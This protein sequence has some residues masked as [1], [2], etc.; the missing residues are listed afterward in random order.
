MKLDGVA[1]FVTIAEAGSISAAARRMG[2]P[3][4]VVS[5]RL[6]ELERFFGVRLMQ[7]TTRRLSL[8][9]DGHA[10]LERATRMVRDAREGAAEM[11]ERRGQLAGPLRISGPSSF[12]V[13]HLGPALYP[14]LAEHPRIEMTLDLD[15]RFVD[16]AADGYDAVV[17]HGPIRDTRLVAKRLAPSRR[18]LCASGAYLAA[19]GTPASL[20]DLERHAAILYLNRDAD[21]RFGG[22][23]GTAVVRPRPGLRINNGLM[24]R[25]AALAG[26]GIALLPTFLIHREL[27]SGTLLALDVGKTAEGADLHVAYPRDRGP[28]AK[29]RALTEHLRRA[30]G[31][32]PYWDVPAMSKP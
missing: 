6:A 27:A 5:E 9:E 19:Q 32:P 24:M 23:D 2:L 26:L 20:D 17:R 22:P 13:L 28:S 29:L 1:A 12:G 7:R 18:V 3:K 14:F 15:D 21:W 30:F 4:S 31:D 11:A 16:V 10:F 8:T 25:D